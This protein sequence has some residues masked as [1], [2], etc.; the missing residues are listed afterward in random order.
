M[1]CVGFLQHRA[2]GPDETR[3][4]MLCLPLDNRE[5]CI[6]DIMVALDTTQSKLS[7][8]LATPMPRCC[9]AGFASSD[10]L[11]AVPFP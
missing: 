3:L 2:H 6:C 1:F 4:A 8:P 7:R 5:T 10:S 9:R 11:I